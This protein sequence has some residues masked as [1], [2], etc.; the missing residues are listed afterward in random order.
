MP[1]CRECGSESKFITAWIEFE[2]SVF[3]NGKCID[4]YAGDRERY[5]EKYPPECMECNS[6]DIENVDDI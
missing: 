6:S 1:R 2:V 4:N 3:Q 5:D